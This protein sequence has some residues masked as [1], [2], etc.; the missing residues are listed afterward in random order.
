[1]NDNAL[2]NV[3]NL[4]ACYVTARETNID[5]EIISSAL[6]NLSLKV[7]RLDNYK[8]FNKD[9]TLLLSKNETPISYNQSLEFVEKQK[10]KKTV[11]IGFDRVSGRYNLKDLSW[12]YDINFELL[13]REDVVKIICVGT[14]AND[15][16]LRLKYAD[17]DSKKVEIYDT[18]KDILNII[19]NRT[20]GKVYCVVYFD[21]FYRLKDLLHKEEK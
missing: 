7:K 8:L 21:I 15:I 10:E 17:I 12:L 5:K 18:S 14:F 1:M 6:N 3:Y 9:I 4:S 20:K 2:Y 19:K 16:A 11:I 13:N